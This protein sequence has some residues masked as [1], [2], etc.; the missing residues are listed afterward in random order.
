[1]TDQNHTPDNSPWYAD[2]LH[3]KC[4]GCGGCCTGDPGFVWVN[5][6]EI[7]KLAES[8]NMTAS[9]FKKQYVRTEHRKTSLCELPD[10]D[11]VFFDRKTMGCKVYAARPI[12][13]RT[14]PFWQSNLR[15]PYAW[16]AT[17]EACPGAGNGPHFTLEEIELRRVEKRL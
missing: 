10:G 9:E 1:M 15:T 16:Q 3:F 11:C 14:W 5:K 7:D 2:G 6:Q 8:L 17:C 13:C 12:Q 4:T